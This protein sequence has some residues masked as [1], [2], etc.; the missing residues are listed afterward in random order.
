[1]PCNSD[2]MS[3]LQWELDLCEVLKHLFY[4]KT[5]LKLPISKKLAQAQGTYYGSHYK[6]DDLS[7]LTAQLCG[8]LRRL[9]PKVLNRIVYNAR[10]SKSRNLADWYE[11]H[12]AADKERQKEERKLKE[13]QRLKQSAKNKLTQKELNALLSED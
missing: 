1:M 6:C 7:P 13:I 8:L 9:E 4:V 2:Y 11:R 5:M 10:N 12:L 3:P